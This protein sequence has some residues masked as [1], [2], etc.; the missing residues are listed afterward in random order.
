MTVR[1][2]DK[3][4]LTEL[5]GTE[6]IPATSIAGGAKE[7]GGTVAANADIHVTPA[8]L[9]A[10]AAGIAIVATV[11][12]NTIT[13]TSTT[14]LVRPSALTAALTIANPTGTA[15]DGWGFV[16][17]LIDDG[18]AHALTWGS[19]Y[20]SNIATLPTTTTVS[21][22]LRVGFEYNSVTSKYECKAVQVQP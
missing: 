17:E 9:R 8:Q 14:D 21:K 15:V 4:K 16:V 5:A 18:T 22:R 6:A 20:A 3:P 1:W 7:G 13:P 12:S 10:Y 11:T 2:K 19:D